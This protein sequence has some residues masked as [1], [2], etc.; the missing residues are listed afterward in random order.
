MKMSEYVDDISFQLGGG[1]VEVEIESSLPTCV[2]KLFRA[3]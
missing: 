3:L 1:I 2:N